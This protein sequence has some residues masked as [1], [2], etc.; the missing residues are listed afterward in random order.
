MDGGD[1]TK[2]KAGAAL[3]GRAHKNASPARRPTLKMIAEI[4]GLG[5]TTV[6]RA[7]KDAPDLAAATKARIR[8]VAEDIGYRPDRA[9]VRLRTGRTN[10][11]SLILSPHDEILGYGSSIIFGMSR[12]LRN[13]PYHLIVTP[14][15]LDA[16]PMEPIRYIMETGSAD[17][18][19]FSRTE[20]MD[21]R[22]RFLLERDFPFVC[23][24]RTELSTPHPWYDYDN[25]AFA[26]EAARRLIVKG[27]RNLVLIRPPRAF[28]FHQHMVHGFM[29]AVSESGVSHTMVD[30]IDLESSPE[31]IREF[32]R[33][34]AGAGDRPDG[35]VCGGEVTAMALVAGLTDAGLEIGRDAD[36]V[37]KQTSNLFDQVIPPIDSIYE[38]L[39]ATGEALAS[40]LLRRIDNEPVDSLQVLGKPTLRYRSAQS[41]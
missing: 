8:K 16:D 39:Q 4:T 19:I 12:S 33:T 25:F 3:S 18:V 30:G 26:Y 15:F 29:T 38:D 34:I 2:D 11:I 5:V 37:A 9:G 40:I 1:A 13:T 41:G 6:S 17:G 28:T 31:R 22:V 10:V 21:E 35:F 36:L 27:R 24:G 14:H 32:G 7:L 23:H 20:P